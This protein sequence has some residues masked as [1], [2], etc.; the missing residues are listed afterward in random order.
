MC[1]GWS[2]I[3]T[4][5]FAA[6]A[7]QIIQRRIVRQIGS[8][9]EALH[10]KNLVHRDLKLDNIALDSAMDVKIIDLGLCNDMSGRESLETQCGSFGYSAPELLSDRPYGKPADLWSLGVC[11]FA[12][13][14]GQLPFEESS[15]LSTLLAM[16]AEQQFSVDP[17]V[18]PE[19]RDLLCMLLQAK[20]SKRATFDKFWEHPWISGEAMG[21]EI[22]RRMLGVMVPVTEA[23]IESE[24]LSELDALGIGRGVFHL[25]S[26]CVE[27]MVLSLWYTRFLGIIASSLIYPPTNSL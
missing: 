25:F 10:S 23:D 13:V 2:L 27:R 14:T 18:S 20:P 26:V 3:L 5:L 12:M 7:H 15:D 9:I 11:L 24:V 8:A 1:A 6:N 17:Q 19:L 4:P 21:I 16:Q 22:E